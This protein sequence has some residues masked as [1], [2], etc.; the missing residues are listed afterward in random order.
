MALRLLAPQIQEA[1]LSGEVQEPVRE[2][3][4]LSHEPNWKRQLENLA[5]R[6]T[7]ESHS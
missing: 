3:R 1:I 2:L 7:R 4:L 5:I 6:T